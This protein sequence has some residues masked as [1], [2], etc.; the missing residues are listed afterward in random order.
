MIFILERATLVNLARKML[1]SHG[2]TLDR[3]YCAP[4]GE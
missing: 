4:P 2:Y 1:Y 3:D